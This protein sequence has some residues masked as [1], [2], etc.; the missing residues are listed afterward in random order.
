MIVTIL[1]INC[2]KVVHSG[3]QV[4]HIIILNTHRAEMFKNALK[5]GILGSM[6]VKDKLWFYY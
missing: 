1:P 3:Q 5:I 6:T 2:R 4:M